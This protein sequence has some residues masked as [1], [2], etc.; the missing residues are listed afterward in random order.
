MTMRKDLLAPALLALGLLGA[1]GSNPDEG[2]TF[3]ATYA[4]LQTFLLLDQGCAGCH[5]GP[6]TRPGLNLQPLMSYGD[7]VDAPA[8]SETWKGTRW[9]GGKLVVPGDP[10]ASLLVLVLEAPQ[11]LPAKLHMPGDEMTVS[12][13]RIDALRRW[14]AAG[15]KDD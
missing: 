4:E 8:Q 15:A 14:I 11:G 2:R 5:Q 6:G 1:C 9:A 10:D 12:P 13:Q 3:P 7:L